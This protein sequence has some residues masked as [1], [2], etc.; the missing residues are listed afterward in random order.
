M[1]IRKNVKISELTTMRLGGAARFVI[2]VESPEE[3]KKAFDFARERSLP[4]FALGGGANTIGHDEGFD[5]VIILNRIK[6]IEVIDETDQNLII[7][8]MGGEIWDD[9]VQF[10]SEKGWSGIE[11][12]TDIPGTLGAAPVQNIGAYGQDVAQVIEKVE[13][14]DTE[15][16]QMA[17][18]LPTEMGMGYRKTIFNHGPN[19][20]RYFI[21]AVTLKLHKNRMTPPFYTSLQNYVDE[22]QVTDFSPMNIRLMVRKIRASKL[23]DPK[24]LASSGSFFKNVMLSDVEAD[25]AEARGIQVYRGQNGKNQINSGWLIEQAGLKG[26]EF[27]GMRVSDKAA[28]I[29]INENAKSYADLARARQYIIDTVKEKFGFTLEQEPVEI[30]NQ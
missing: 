20:G 25:T 22:H 23:P 29:L 3:V 17:T 7:R 8:G 26:Q 13:A 27:F 19:A 24:S 16:N 21:V 4:T 30:I 5:G 15:T 12:L 6:G 14:F 18:I 28:L 10:T 9:V 2:E 1:K 11:A